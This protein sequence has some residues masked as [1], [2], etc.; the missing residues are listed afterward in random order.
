MDQPVFNKFTIWKTVKT[1]S[2]GNQTSSPHLNQAQQLLPGPEQHPRGHR[3][4]RERRR[5]LGGRRHGG[6][7]DAAHRDGHWRRRERGRR[8]RGGRVRG[9]VVEGKVVLLLPVPQ[10]MLVFNT[11]I[12]GL[13]IRLGDSIC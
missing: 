11:I 13:A 7:R 10:L 6:Q 5:G 4:G 9:Q 12:T 2:K 3:G 8:R 1:E